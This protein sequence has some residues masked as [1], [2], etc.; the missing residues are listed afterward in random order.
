MLPTCVMLLLRAFR[1]VVFSLR[2]AAKRFR[3]TDGDD[4]SGTFGRGPDGSA[5]RQRL[6]RP[7][8]PGC[9]ARPKS[10]RR[11]TS[12]LKT[13]APAEA[14]YPFNIPPK[15]EV[16]SETTARSARSCRRGHARRA[17]RRQRG[18]AA[19]FVCLITGANTSCAAMCD[20]S[21]APPRLPGRLR[22]RADRHPRFLCMSLKRLRVDFRRGVVSVCRTRLRRAQPAPAVPRDSDCVSIDL[23][24]T[25]ACAF[26]ETIHDRRAKPSSK[27][28]CDDGDPCTNDS[29]DKATGECENDLVTLDLDGDGHSSR[30]SPDGTCGDDCD[31][32][33]P[34]A[35]P[36]NPEVCD[37]VDND[38]D[39]IVDNGATY[40][41]LAGATSNSRSPA[42]TGPSPTCF[43]AARRRARCNLIATYDA[44][45]AGQLTPFVQPLDALGKPRDRSDRPH[46]Q[47]SPRAAARRSRG[48]AI[49]SASR[50]AIAATATSRSISRSSTRRKEDGAR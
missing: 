33:D 10:T 18:C 9:G 27:T 40:T 37:G 23:C 11:A 20:R 24:A 45:Q 43:R 26:D 25:Y 5:R 36:G 19:G 8:L 28:N 2:A 48:P 41:P 49:A 17:V 38:C 15:N 30:H 22:V 12:S 6:R 44:S 47:R 7:T 14:C 29:C 31:D 4:D 1:V 32:T 34:R 42:S 46:G 21:A 13:A 50:G 16:Q 35:F 3:P 39:G